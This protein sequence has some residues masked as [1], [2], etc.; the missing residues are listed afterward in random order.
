MSGFGFWSHD[1]G[2]F[3]GIPDAGVFKRWTAFGL[4]GSHSRFHGSSSYRVPWMF[5]NEAVDVTRIFTKLKLKLMP[6][7]YAVGLEASATGAPVMRPMQLEFPDDPA[8]GHLDRQYMLGSDILVA[9]VF[10]ASGDVEFYLPA[11]TRTNYFTRETVEGGSWRRE[12]HG[13]TSLPLYVREGAVIPTGA[14]DDRPDYDYL[15]GLVLDLF[16]GASGTIT[17][18]NPAGEAATF[19][20]ADGSVTSDSD[21]LFA[22]RVG[23]GEPIRS[24]AGK[25]DTQW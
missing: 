13:F 8:V 6:Y 2:G 23:N 12:N 11:G 3:E 22:V 20:V 16:P 4:L 14:R 5:D 10:T 9:P 1:I 24:E 19:T 21:R 7:L 15:D 17:V 25:V 18:T